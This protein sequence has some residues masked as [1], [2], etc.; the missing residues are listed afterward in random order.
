MCLIKSKRLCNPLQNVWKATNP[1]AVISPDGL[2]INSTGFFGCHIFAEK[3]F[4]ISGDNCRMDKFT[5]TVLYYYEVTHLENTLIG[6]I[7]LDGL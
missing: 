2:K 6:P 7:H 3:G 5:G 4:A 1:G